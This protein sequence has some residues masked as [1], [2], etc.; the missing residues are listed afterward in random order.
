MVSGE[1]RVLMA[2]P[3][4]VLFHILRGTCVAVLFL[5]PPVMLGNA[6]YSHRAGIWQAGG[7]LDTIETSEMWRWG[8]RQVP[9]VRRW[10]MPSSKPSYTALT[11]QVVGESREPRKSIALCIGDI[12]HSGCCFN[13]RSGMR[14]LNVRIRAGCGPSKLR[15]SNTAGYIG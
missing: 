13:V 3:P 9:E 5:L 1:Y 7:H 4:M 8:E 6:R 14:S 12:L 11:H 10:S 15:R 2:C